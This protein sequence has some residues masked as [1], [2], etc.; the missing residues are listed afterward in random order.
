MAQAECAPAFGP[1]NP[2]LLYVVRFPSWAI[3]H[4]SVQK[5]FTAVIAAFQSVN[6]Y[7]L[8]HSNCKQGTN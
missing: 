3:R 4:I 2:F 8:R 5:V 1:Q 7:V 6:Y